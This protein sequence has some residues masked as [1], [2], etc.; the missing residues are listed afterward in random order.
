MAAGPGF[1]WRVRGVS[2]AYPWCV[3]SL[4]VGTILK[5]KLDNPLTIE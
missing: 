5:E 1:P 3:G 2:V 4:K